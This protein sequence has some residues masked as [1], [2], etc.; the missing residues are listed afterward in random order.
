MSVTAKRLSKSGARGKELD[1]IVR[2]QLQILDD[3]LIHHSRSWGKNVVSHDLPVNLAMPGLD[4][5]DAQRIVY[6]AIIRSLVKREF[7]VRLLLE[8]SCTTIYIAW[9]TDLDT[10]EIQ[11]MNQQIRKVRITRELLPGFLADA[12]VSG[13]ERTPGPDKKAAQVV[14]NSVTPFAL[15]S[16]G[17]QSS[18]VG[19]KTGAAV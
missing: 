19:A 14:A 13:H 1:A 9:V 7:E 17:T 4:K 2:E 10:E 5:R 11:A 16:A 12:R 18:M 6:S 15:S 3:K 8:E